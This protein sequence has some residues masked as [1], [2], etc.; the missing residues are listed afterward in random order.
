MDADGWLHTGD[1]AI[2]T[3]EGNIK[4]VDRRK[5]IFKLSQGEYIAVEKVEGVYGRSPFVAQ[6]F[7][8]G[9]S[10][11]SCLVA[12]VVPDADH[13]KT[14]GPANGLDGNDMEAACKSNAFRDAVIEDMR[15]VA[16]AGKL[17]GFEQAR[18]I[19]LHPEP[20][21]VENELLTPTFKLKRPQAKKR[22]QEQIDF[23][24]AD[25][26]IG[27]VGGRTGLKQSDAAGTGAG[28]GAGQ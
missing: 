17:R 16:K 5:N 10:F 2:F 13:L 21:S 15:R 26:K 24:Y 27:N 8:Y 6:T 25:P 23:M 7:V 22:F 28:A 12:I 18:S 14:W 19:Y 9:D 1:I 3:P 4:I 20:F 11:Q